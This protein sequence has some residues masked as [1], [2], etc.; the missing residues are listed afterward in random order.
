MKRLHYLSGLTLSIFI[1]LHLF[2]HLTG[3]A[4]A[5]AHINWMEQLRM[6]YRNP[7]AETLL[8]GAVLLQIVTGLK[9][10]F[11][12]RSAANKGYERLQLWTGLYLGFFLLIHVSAVLAGRFILELDTNFYFGV[13]GLNTFP[14]NLF[15]IPYYALAIFSFFGHVAAIHHQKMKS[16]V[17]GLSVR[18]Q[19]RLIL[20]TGLLVLLVIFYGLTDGFT[21]VVIP[22]EYHVLINQ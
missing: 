11:T 3:L 10:F 12:K 15:F 6:L 8:L 16:E 4:G 1:G 18:Q 17:L 19:A 13:A 5:E 14:F 21:G 7:I 9:L 2:N 20:I 22:E